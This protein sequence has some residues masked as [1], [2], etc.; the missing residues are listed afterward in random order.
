MYRNELDEI[1]AAHKAVL[2]LT[3]KN[4]L[5]FW[6]WPLVVY[7]AWVLALNPRRGGGF[8]C[9]VR[10]EGLAPPKVDRPHGLQPCAIAAPPP[11]RKFVK[12]TAM[13]CV[14]RRDLVKKSLYIF[15]FSDVYPVSTRLRYPV[16]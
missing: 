8:L 5:F 6:T 15:T 11:T 10:R 14:C 12:S 3:V 4:A 1:R 13:L 9:M 7:S 16:S 2:D